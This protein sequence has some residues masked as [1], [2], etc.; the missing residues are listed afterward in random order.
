MTIV[1]NAINVAKKNRDGKTNDKKYTPYLLVDRYIEHIKDLVETT[2]IIYEPFAGDGRI[3][4][5]LREKFPNN[6]IEETEIDNGT[7]FFEFNE[8]VDIIISNPPYSCIDTVLSHS[9]ALKP[10]VISYLIGMINFSPKRVTYMNDNGYYID[11]ILF[12][13]VRN[14]FGITSII[15]FSNKIKKNCIDV[16]RFEYKYVENPK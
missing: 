1:G 4:N 15:T 2:D 11:R 5:A 8:S 3:V 9:I 10:R 6:K 14:W 13:R 12:C 16:D 7:N